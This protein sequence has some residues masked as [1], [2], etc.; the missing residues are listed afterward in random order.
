MGFLLGVMLRLH[1]VVPHLQWKRTIA[2]LVAGSRRTK[3]KKNA[4]TKLALSY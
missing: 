2:L 3:P 1:Y 4:S